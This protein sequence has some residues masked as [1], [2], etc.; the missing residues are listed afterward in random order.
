MPDATAHGQDGGRR[1][2][3]VDRFKSWALPVLAVVLAA[4]FGTTSLVNGLSDRDRKAAEAAESRSAE[5]I[6]VCEVTDRKDLAPAS[7]ALFGVNLNL[8]AKPLAQYAADLGHKPAVS[9]SFADFPY[10]AEESVHLQQAAAQIR[11]DGHMMLLTLEPKQGLAAITPDTV[12]GLVNDL[13]ALNAEGVP[14]IVR[15]AHEM[16]GS[17]YP[18]SQQPLEYKD[19]FTR[20]A[21]AVHTGAPGSAM[22]WAPNYAGGYPFAGGQYEA[23]PGTP[24]FEALDTDHDGTLT[25]ADDSYSPYYPGD[26]A[27]DWVGMS[28]YHWGAR[29]PWGENETPEANKFADQLTGTYAGANGDDTLLPDFY[30][31]YGQAHGKPVAIPE[32]AALYNPAAGGAAEIDI[33]RIW[34]EQVFSPDTAARFPNLKMINWFE[35]DKNEAEVNGRIDWTATNTPTIRDAFTN[36]LP[37]WL[38]YGTGT[39]CRAAQQ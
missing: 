26:E 20:V 12:T 9:V 19:A 30:Q 16:N 3:F 37:D 11:A 14:V 25:M 24:D 33:K 4:G 31:I 35:W 18:W 8:D 32:T 36:A 17:W 39:S 29:Y 27:V 1:D 28:L 13:A 22:M 5:T 34:W 23:K 21:A 6:P 15:L 38:H 7:G 10:T 2:D